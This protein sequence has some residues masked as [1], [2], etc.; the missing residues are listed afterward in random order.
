MRNRHHYK[1]HTTHFTILKGKLQDLAN[2]ATPINGSHEILKR[3]KWEDIQRTFALTSD[4][5]KTSK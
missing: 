4:I 5:T 3:N 1:L 2:K